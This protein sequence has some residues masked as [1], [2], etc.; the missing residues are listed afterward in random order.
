MYVEFVTVSYFF[1]FVLLFHISKYVIR[2]FRET[3]FTMVSTE[4]KLTPSK[5]AP[6]AYKFILQQSI[7]VEKL[8]YSKGAK[9]FMHNTKPPH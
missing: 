1:Q 5:F 4:F 2:I 6:Q 3:F 7:W 9:L 8:L